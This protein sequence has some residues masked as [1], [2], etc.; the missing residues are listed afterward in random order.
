MHEQIIKHD[1][2]NADSKVGKV[3]EHTYRWT[4]TYTTGTGY[5][6]SAMAT[7]AHFNERRSAK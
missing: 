3:V 4:P 7:K 2:Y 1:P 6:V 5:N